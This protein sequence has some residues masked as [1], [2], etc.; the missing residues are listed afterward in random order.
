MPGKKEDDEEDRK[1]PAKKTIE[2]AKATVTKVPK[3]KKSDGG[4]LPLLKTAPP[5]AFGAVATSALL[6]RMCQ[7][8]CEAQDLVLLR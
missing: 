4:A 3:K 1:L 8:R 5:L 6:S 2:R 7:T